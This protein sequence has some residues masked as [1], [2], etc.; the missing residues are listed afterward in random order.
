M[1][2]ILKRCELPK[3]Q[4]LAG[5]CACCITDWKSHVMEHGPSP[6][7]LTS[8]ASQNGNADH[9]VSPS[10]TIVSRGESETSDDSNQPILNRAARNQERQ[11]AK[12]E[13]FDEVCTSSGDENP[14][15]RSS[16]VSRMKMVLPG[17]V[18][19]VEPFRSD[20]T[21]AYGIS[22]DDKDI[23]WRVREK[24][25]EDFQEIVVSPKMLRDHFPN[26]V[27]SYLATVTN[28]TRRRKHQE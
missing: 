10:R 8:V 27:Q 6:S 5:I 24:S 25:W 15:R 21:E 4:I 14:G 9:P 26:H 17:S 20:G 12:Y 22:R 3:Y 19:H 1:K 11:A 18:W 28:I 13:S 16:S 2:D 23:E 7:R